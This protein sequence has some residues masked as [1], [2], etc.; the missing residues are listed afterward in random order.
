MK[1]G[2]AKGDI[3]P[4]IG[5]QIPGGFKKRVGRQVI[6]PLY[7]KAVV[8]DDTKKSVALVQ[9]DAVSVKIPI[10]RKI[11]DN[12]QREIGIPGENIMIAATH[13]HSGGPA[14]DSFESE[15]DA[16]YLNF[17]INRVTTTVITAYQNRKDAK[18]ASG[19]G[20]EESIAF[21]RRFLMKDGTHKTHP[22]K[23]NSDIINP[24]GPID[25]AVGVIGVWDLQDNF[26]G[27]VV[28]YTCHCTVI[29]EGF[30]GDYPFFLSKVIRQVMD[31]NSTVVFLNG[32]C[33]DVTQ[34][35][36]QIIREPEFGVKWAK[37]IGQILASECLKVIARME[38][39]NGWNVALKS[40]KVE[41]KTRQVPA[42]IL[43]NAQDL[44]S[45]EN[46][47]D[48]EKYYAMEVILLDEMNEKESQANA[49][50]M[51][52]SIGNCVF[53]SVPAELFCEFGL[54]IK[55]ASPYE[56]TFV[57]GYANGNVGYVPT[58]KAMRKGG[59]EIRLARHSKLTPDAGEKIVKRASSVLKA[60]PQ[61]PQKEKP[62]L[63][64]PKLW[65][66]GAFSAETSG[67]DF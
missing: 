10:V 58:E 65:Y 57:V 39:T 27:C 14:E 41:L 38:P 26:L 36:N 32:A 25:P 28:N 6:T 54:Q 48:I 5:C 34:V 47:N 46:E 2:F 1:V 40:T 61:P 35:S 22:G 7:A 17:L 15:A 42:R 23:G 56:R 30:S 4:W 29:G 44:L 49:E 52:I 19:I 11:R 31:D 50:I 18:I 8:F 16:E 13:D 9:V 62:E 24:A 66:P 51:A 20:N 59:Y 60:L 53:I 37:R 45:R 3:T 67:L 12:V 63:P 21:N 33:G 43:K 64:R 55:Q